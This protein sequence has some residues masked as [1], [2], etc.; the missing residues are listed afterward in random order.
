MRRLALL[1]LPL[2]TLILAIGG[3]LSSQATEP[4]PTPS[5]SPTAPHI[6]P[7]PDLTP[8]PS[9]DATPAPSP[10]PAAGYSG[11]L[12]LGDWVQITGTDSCLNARTQPGTS[13]PYPEADPNSLILN[14]LPDGFIGRLSNGGGY[15]PGTGPV[16]ADGH[17]WWYMVGQGWVA[18]D[19]LAFHH[20]GS[21]FWPP[22]SD[23]SGAG[24]IAY[25]GNDNSIWLMNAD[26]SDQH[27]IVA[28]A[29]E[30][31]S[32]SY[33]TW[34][35]TG[36]H[37]SFSVAAWG[38]KEAPAPYS[39]ST[40]VV[41]VS[42]A[43]VADLP[44]LTAAAWSPD[45][46]RI[47]AIRVDQPADM[48]GQHGTPLVRDMVS[49]AETAIG[50]AAWYGPAPIWSPDGLSL[51]FYCSSGIS[52]TL[53]PDG[54]VLESRTDCGG[55]DGLRIVTTD[56]ASL[57]VILTTGADQGVY[58]G[59]SS[60]SPAGDVIAVASY[61][62]AESGCRG[63]ILV[64]VQTGAAGSCFPFPPAGGFGGCG[65]NAET[66][67]SD[68]TPDARYLVHHG[69]FGGGNNGV[70]IVEVATGEKTLIPVVPVSSITIAPSGRQLA[71]AGAGN[72]WIA[73]ID[74]ANPAPIAEGA[75]PAWQPTS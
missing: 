2:V 46:G 58:Y 64:N 22:R 41:D 62:S 37:L 11:S 18:E 36:Q 40:R 51:A 21:A 70:W 4:S 34:S 44:S 45:G 5:P 20:E 6:E 61:P 48:G 59:A 9:P 12:K 60:W 39:V 49:G 65:F 19:W 3:G 71:F 67:A 23:L 68:W 8:A 26:G 30:T 50:P 31:E 74:G 72:I 7:T 73:D 43:V 29:G 25:I 13:L 52:S 63:Y 47:S 35:P 54:T 10:A 27:Q 17:W 33:L 24:L 38:T 75:S 42:G 57:R 1:S 28:R 56:G 14:C 16:N 55:S 32:F 15:E 53:Q 69:Q 66:G